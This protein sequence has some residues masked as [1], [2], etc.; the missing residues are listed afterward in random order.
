V[1]ALLALLV[2][3]DV[4]QTAVVGQPTTLAEP[5]VRLQPQTSEA[6][7]EYIEESSDGRRL[8]THDR[9]FAPR[10]WD[11]A[12]G[13]LLK[14]LGNQDKTD[15]VTFSRDGKWVLTQSRTDVRLWTSDKGSLSRRWQAAEDEEVAWAALSPDGATV[16]VATARGLVVFPAASPLAVKRA[17]VLVGLKKVEFSLDGATIVGVDHE[18]GVGI[19]SSTTA[20]EARQ[21][22]ADGLVALWASF[23]PDGALVSASGDGRAV[24]FDAATGRTLWSAEHDVAAKGFMQTTR[25]AAEFVVGGLVVTCESGGDMVLRDGRTGAEKGRL[26]GHK[27]GIRELRRTLDAKHLATYADDNT[28]RIW[29]VAGRKELRFELPP[30]ASPTA[31]EFSP[32][33]DSFW[34][35]DADGAIREHRLADAKVAREMR[36]QI[37]PFDQVWVT[38]QALYFDTPVGTLRRD[39]KRPSDSAF[40]WTTNIEPVLS[41]DGTRAIVQKGESAWL[42]DTVTGATVRTSKRLDGAAFSPDSGRLVVWSSSRYVELWDATKGEVLGGFD[43]DGQSP[44]SAALLPD[45]KTIVSYGAATGRF[46]V[47]DGIDGKV[48]GRV[49][50]GAGI[51]SVAASPDGKVALACAADRLLAM[52]TATGATLWDVRRE[53]GGHQWASFSPNGSMIAV[54]TYDRLRLLSATD[55]SEVWSAPQDSWA[56]S[57][58][59]R[60]FSPDGRLVLTVDRARATLHEAA[61]GQERLRFETSGEVSQA[62]FLSEGRLVGTVDD[63][64]GLTV[65]ST[66]PKPIADGP[67]LR[68]MAQR[69]GSYVEM[70]DG[71]WLALDPEGRYDAENPGDVPGACFVLDWSG[72]L[73]PVEVPQLKQQFYEPGLLAKVLGLDD[74]PVRPVPDLQKLRLY[75]EARLR[76]DTADPN[77]VDVSVTPR[78]DGGI[79]RVTVAL[80]GKRVASRRGTGFFSLDLSAYRRYFLPEASL[81]AGRGNLLSVTVSNEAGDLSS[82]PVTLDV[83]VPEGLR[84]P[85]VRLHALFVGVGDYAGNSWDLAAPGKDASA[86]AAAVTAAAERLL[87]GRV[88]ATVLRTGATTPTRSAILAWFKETA[89][90]AASSDIVMVFMAGHGVSQIGERRDYFFLTAEADPGDLGVLSADSAA[91]S[92][93]DLRQALSEVAASKQVVVLDT[94]QSGAAAGSLLGDG[95]AAGGD[96]QRAYEAIKDATGTWLLAGAAADQRSYESPNVEHGVLT[97]ALLE[98][99]DR[100]SPDG[101]RGG[102]GGDLFLDV[103]RWLTYAAGRVESLKNEVGLTGIQR[104]EFKRSTGGPSFDLGVV[105]ESARG[106]LGLKPPRPVVIVGTFE[107]DQEDPAGLEE[108][109][110]SAMQESERVK[111]WLDVAKHPRAYRVAGEYT[112]DGEAVKLKVFLQ[113][114]DERGQRKTLETFELAGTKAG[115]ADLAAAV[116]REAES[117]ITRLE[118]PAGG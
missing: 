66:T 87:P 80:N 11:P 39:P 89:A 79:G 109:V 110:R 95:R 23:S 25:M 59:A 35:G 70:R 1:T 84:T 99:I 83:G 103:E 12:A 27:G 73:E 54:Q 42:I 72:G 6:R 52:D 5:R 24:V 85:D 45:G 30:D 49:E 96:Y 112:L 31:G 4:R 81:P 78:D 104:P 69:L 115:L 113:R 105:P 82:P 15:L 46:E 86:L 74:D 50:L 106:A 20:K 68:P 16:A 94:C 34:V 60:P 7:L 90:R 19:W 43:L 62:V 91:V 13:R 63:A 67:G 22:R 114:F 77:K 9:G 17:D 71:T 3:A 100:A 40:V 107:L 26:T 47:W 102:E 116:R 33:G 108:A 44:A 93:E 51:G 97:Y 2:L 117:R 28:L 21:L 37:R 58:M 53:D 101:L 56:G 98:A 41:P 32:D 57:H 14:V 8:L 76:P 10:L 61:T 18:G 111:A 64:N 48:I 92:G 65:W 29:N 38:P 36:G 118:A 88:E 75:P 55:G